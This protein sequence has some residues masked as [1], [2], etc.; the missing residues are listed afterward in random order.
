M[1][2]AA[3]RRQL[4]QTRASPKR[5]AFVEVPRHRADLRRWIGH[6]SEDFRFPTFEAAIKTTI[7][8]R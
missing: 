1:R 2:L 4:G 6:P 8:S 5:R 3:L 7:G